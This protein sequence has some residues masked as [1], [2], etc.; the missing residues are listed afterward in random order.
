MNSLKGH[1]D[2]YLNLKDV[3]LLQNLHQKYIKLLYI[4]II[5]IYNQDFVSQ[6]SAEIHFKLESN[7]R[8]SLNGMMIAVKGDKLC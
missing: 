4:C 7:V 2:T 3:N 8:I 5:H 6:K 1:E